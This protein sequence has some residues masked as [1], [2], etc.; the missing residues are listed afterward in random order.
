MTHAR[1][2][3]IVAAYG[4]DTRRWPATERAATFAAIAEDQALALPYADARALDALLDE[5]AGRDVRSG[6]PA[7]AAARVLRPA[8]TWLRFAGGSGMVA[9]VVAAVIFGQPTL[10]LRRAAPTPQIALAATDMSAP[11]DAAAFR[12]LFTPTPDEENTL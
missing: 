8:R 2:F 3:E 4:A 6:D 7:A 11:G 1:A 9:T 10:L 5:W 12:S